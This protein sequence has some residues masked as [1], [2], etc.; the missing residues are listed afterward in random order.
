MLSMKT[1]GHFDDD[2]SKRPDR[3]SIS[4]E[5]VDQARREPE[6]VEHQQNGRTKHWIYVEGRERWLR[7]MVLEDG[8]TVHTKFWDRGFE[9]KLQRFEQGHEWRMVRC[10]QDED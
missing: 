1:S 10:K 3:I 5:W 2:V 8:E 7:I 4:D 9:E 6:Y